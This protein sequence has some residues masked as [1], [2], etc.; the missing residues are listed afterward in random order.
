MIPVNNKLG[1]SQSMDAIFNFITGSHVVIQGAFGSA[2]FWVIL[3]AGQYIF[4][5]LGAKVS[6]V[7]TAYKE[8]ALYREYIQKKLSRGEKSHEM[9]SMCTYQALSY[10]FRGFAFLGLGFIMSD[11]IP[12]S[13]SIGGLGFLFYLFRALGWL[14]PFHIGSPEPELKLWS[15]IQ[16]IEQELFGSVKTDT[17]EKL[18]ELSDS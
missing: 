4:S 14:K 1:V 6:F 2:L 8:E 18:D 13:N 15:R 10:L 11:F 7:N 12:L 5:F 3:V 9:I 16:E 17:K